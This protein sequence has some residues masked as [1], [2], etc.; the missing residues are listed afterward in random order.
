MLLFGSSHHARRHAIL[1][2]KGSVKITAVLKA[3]LISN[4]RYGIRRGEQSFFRPGKPEIFH[5]FQRRRLHACLKTPDRL[6]FADICR[7]GNIPQRDPFGKM[8][9]NKLHHKAESCLCADCHPRLFHPHDCLPVFPQLF[10]QLTD[11]DMYSQLS[12]AAVGRTEA[13]D[14]VQQLQHFPLPVRLLPQ[15]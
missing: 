2:L 14:V 12:F 8:I 13:V 10:P 3:R 6:A 15:N 5:T 9:L 11:A 1:F 4:V 7:R